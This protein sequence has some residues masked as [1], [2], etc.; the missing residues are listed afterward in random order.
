MMLLEVTRYGFGHEIDIEY[1]L[2]E[3]Q[4]KLV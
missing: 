3:Y 4:L 1:L 2:Y